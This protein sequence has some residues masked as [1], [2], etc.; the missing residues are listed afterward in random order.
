MKRYGLLILAGLVW[1]GV[2]CFRNQTSE[3]TIHV[4]AMK[5][6]ECEFVVKQALAPLAGSGLDMETLKIS[7]ADQTV[8]VSFDNMRMGR[9]NIEKA[10]A[11]A[12]FSANDLPADESARRK[13]SAACQ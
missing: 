3:I 2:G 10:I 11:E 5:T 8:V 6:R 4:P 12:G 7:S 9:R 13:L 1:A